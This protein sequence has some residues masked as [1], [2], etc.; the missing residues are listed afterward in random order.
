MVRILIDLYFLYKFQKIIFVFVVACRKRLQIFPE[1]FP[2]YV[3]Y[4]K[5]LKHQN[6]NVKLD[7]YTC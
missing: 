3:S 6:K 7:F 4:I 5:F 1:Y 2:V